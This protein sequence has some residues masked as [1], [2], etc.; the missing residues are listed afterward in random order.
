MKPYAQTRIV[1]IGFGF[2]MGYIAP[3][4]TQF[5]DGASVR[6]HVIAVTAD[7]KALEAKRRQYP[8]PVLLNDNKKALEQMKPDIILFAPPPSVAPGLAEEVLK[9]YF[10]ACRAAG[11]ALPD[12]YAF[13]PSPQGKFYLDLLGADIHVCNILPNMMSQINGVSLN[14]AEGNTHVTIPAEGPWPEENRKRLEQ[15]FAPFGGVVYVPTENVL[16]MLATLCIIEV[17][18]L[19]LFDMADA[20]LCDAKDLA[21][22]MRGWHQAHYDYHPVGSTPC[23]I[24]AAPEEAS[25]VLKRIGEAWMKATVEF[26]ISVGM[27]RETAEKILVANMDLK[28]HC[29]QLQDRA[30][31]ED[32]LRNHATKGGVAERARMCYELLLEPVFLERFRDPKQLLADDGFFRLCE[33]T[34]FEISRI[35][36]VHSRKLDGDTASVVMKPDHAAMLFALFVRNAKAMAGEAGAKAAHEG[37]LLYADQRGSRMAKQAAAHGDPNSMIN[38][39]AYGEWEALP[40]TMTQENVALTPAVV[41]HVSQCPWYTIW[42]RLGFLEEGAEYCRYIDYHL[43]KGY[44]PELE[45]GVTQVRTCGAPYCEFI[46]NGCA[47]DPENAAYLA[48]RKEA[49]GDSCRKDWVFHTRHTYSAMREKLLALPNGQQIVS[50]TMDDFEVLYGMSARR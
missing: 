34:A 5:F 43:V 41:T 33:T 7:E 39:M 28:L 42:E 32:D 12:L 14:G 18:P 37:L 17:V 13:P 2:L 24:H 16:D 38:Y 25:Q 50:K 27:T 23:D 36:A 21:S 40:G 47:L 10:D 48:R 29:C 19:L 45:L 4:Y 11:E 22:A 15:I 9:P 44:N 49:L 3:C 26:L 6:D 31:T 46:W 30:K 8:F 35:V 20:T 1:V